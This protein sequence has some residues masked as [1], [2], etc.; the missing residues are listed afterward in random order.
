MV[1][2]GSI[3]WGGKL[4]IATSATS[5]GGYQNSFSDTGKVVNNFFGYLVCNDGP[6]RNFQDNILA[7]RSVSF[8][9]FAMSTAFSL[10]LRIVAEVE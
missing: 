3:D 5:T 2:W 6:Y 10:M 9:A 8:T 7:V 1:T 4:G